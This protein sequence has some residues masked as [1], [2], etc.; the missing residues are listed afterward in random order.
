MIDTTYFLR[1]TTLTIK[2]NDAQSQHDTAVIIS[3]FAEN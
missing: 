3:L 1:W 2:K